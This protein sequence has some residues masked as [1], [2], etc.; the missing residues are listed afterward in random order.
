MRKRVIS[1]AWCGTASVTSWVK[2]SGRWPT[3]VYAAMAPQSWP[4]STAS[5]VAGE[6]VGERER[7]ERDRCD[8]VVA[9]GREPGRRVAAEPRRDDVVARG[10]QLG[11]E[12]LP[13]RR[14][15]GEAVEAERERTVGRARPRGTRSR[16]RWP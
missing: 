14:V 13:G 5:R 11:H 15:V 4:M 6:R 12:V 16:S 8:L 9:V 1:A 2:R 7:V 10:G 3:A